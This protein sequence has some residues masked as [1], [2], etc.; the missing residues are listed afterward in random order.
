[1]PRALPVRIAELAAALD[2]PKSPQTPRAFFDR[3]TGEIEHVPFEVEDESLFADIFDSPTRFVQIPPAP[4]V[5][6]HR[7]RARFLDEV[8]DPQLRIQLTE[9][10]DRPKG[11]LPE[12]DRILRQARA[13]R[14]AWLRYRDRAFAQKARAWLASLDIVPIEDDG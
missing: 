10:L 13:G 11:A 14:E 4:A 7:V 12:F 2:Q 1:M 3:Q 9:A 8:T 5:E 6:R